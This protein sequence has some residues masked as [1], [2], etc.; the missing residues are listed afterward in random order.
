MSCSRLHLKLRGG[1][2]A[3]TETL[4]KFDLAASAS[5]IVCSTETGSR[6]AVSLQCR[7]NAPLTLAVGCS[8]P[9]SAF[10][11]NTWLSR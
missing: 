6:D 11:S 10:E 4:C 2:T 9:G 8:I 3:A 5:A 7:K 1:L